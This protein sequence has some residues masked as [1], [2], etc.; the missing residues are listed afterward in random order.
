M[1]I[2][3]MTKKL[4]TGNLARPRGQSYVAGHKSNSAQSHSATYMGQAQILALLSFYLISYIIS[5]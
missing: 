5:G 4:V 1:V 3:V 2:D